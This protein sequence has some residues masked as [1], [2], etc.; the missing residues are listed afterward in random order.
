MNLKTVEKF[1]VLRG[2]K[3][4]RLR[5]IQNLVYKNFISDW[6]EAH[7][8][9]KDLKED[10]LKKVN[11]LSF[12]VKNTLKSK[13]SNSV[14]A[15][16][17]LH[18]KNFIETVLLETSPENFSICISTQVGCA[19]KCPFCATGKLGFK[20]NLS[21]EEITD[22]TLFWNQY[23]KKEKIAGRIGNVVFMGMGEPF[24]NYD[25]VAQ[26]LRKLISPDFFGLA[27]RHISVSTFGYIPGIRKFAKDFP[28]VNL[29]ISLHASHNLL[30]NKLVPFNREF[31][32]EKLSKV[33]G[34]YVQQT[35]RKVFIEYVLMQGVND[36]KKDA[37]KLIKWL[38]KTAS[39]KY[40]TV[41]IIPYNETVKRF[42]APTADQAKFF[43]SQLQLFGV[44]A[45]VRKSLGSDIQG[46][47]GQ[48]A[49]RKANKAKKTKK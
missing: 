15:L 48:L 32:L 35:H 2:H 38:K 23:L 40:F 31:P 19:V 20:R 24:F 43:E 44:G 34:E 7:V 4:F 39:L 30:R 17:E 27:S 46:A 6:N 13:N 3:K 28:Q 14:K 49:G 25:L 8:L 33:L 42:K 12:T 47:C 9:P 45:T 36:S 22:Q 18:D 10:L 26:S 21:E 29:A 1:L 5:Q 16:F 37:E 11:I 41:N